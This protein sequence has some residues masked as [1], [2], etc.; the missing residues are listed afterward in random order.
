MSRRIGFDRQIK[1]D[2]LDTMAGVVKKESDMDKIRQEMH[3]YLEI[4][5]PLY[6]ARK[7]TITVLSRIW[8]KVP[9]EHLDIRNRGLELLPNLEQKDRIWIHWGL[10]LLAFPFVRD[11]ATYLSRCFSLNDNCSIQEV[12]RKME[13][14][15]GYRTTIKR[16]LNRVIQSFCY[17]DI[18]VKDK[19]SGIIKPKIRLKSYDKSLNLW[20]LEAILLAEN[21]H[22]IPIDQVNKIPS[23]FPFD[24]SLNYSDILESNRFSVNQIT[25]S[26]AMI[27][28]KSIN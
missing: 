13:E 28:V 24:F 21:D 17:W 11:I 22:S 4:E 2:W 8:Y 1:L 27:S 14:S 3:S 5:F 25:G 16:A 20:L 12:T 19:K 23:G 6:V 15:W 26:R 7:K 18:I 10:T 9:K